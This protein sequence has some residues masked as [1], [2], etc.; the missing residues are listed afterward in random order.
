VIFLL[1]K[2]I[3]DSFLILTLTSSSFMTMIIHMRYSGGKGK[4]FQH[5]INLMPP[6]GTYIESHLGGGAVLRNKAPAKQSIGIDKD[7]KVIAE[8]K[9]RYPNLCQLIHADATEYLKQYK[10]DGNELIY[11]DPPYVHSTRRRS[12]IYACEYTNND[13]EQLLLIL[14]KLPSMVLISGYDNELYNDTL[15]GWRKETFLAKTWTDVRQECV[16]LNFKPPYRLHDA[17]YLGANFR[18][19]Q[20]VKRRQQ[21]LREHI[22]QMNPLERSELI[23]WLEATYGSNL[24]ED[25]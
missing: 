3:I 8:W 24:L 9:K 6:H 17:T 14:Q 15:V 4:C 18:E 7:S 19:R 16:W 20:T 22:Q 12:R 1:R 2:I 23:R 5:L 13:H 21:R 10:F 25:A 11:A